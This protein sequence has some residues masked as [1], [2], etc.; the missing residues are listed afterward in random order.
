MNVLAKLSFAALV[1]VG[2]GA[3]AFHELHAQ[4]ALPAYVISE[5]DVLDENGYANQYIPLAN[6]ALATSG[7][8]RLALTGN[9]LTIA[10]EPPRSRIALSIFE[11]MDKAKA[12]YTSQA[13]LDA[14][15]TG[16]KYAKIR[17]FAFEGAPL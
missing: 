3:G 13:Y 4:D 17:I 8:K 1:G 15:K 7:Q 14:L 10:G 2:L 6:K 5:I 11:S 9:T 12:V 16:E